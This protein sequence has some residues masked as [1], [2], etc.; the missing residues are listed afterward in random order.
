[1][2]LSRPFVCVLIGLGMTLYSWF[3]R[4]AWPAF[5]AL[6]T[7]QVVFGTHRDFAD[8]PFAARGAFVVVLIVVNVAAWALIAWTLFWIAGRLRRARTSVNGGN[9]PR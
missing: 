8:L 6:T 3:S 7:M 9:A 1:M 5:P 2:R 4:W